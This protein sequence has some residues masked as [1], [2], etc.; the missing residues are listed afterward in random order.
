MLK[1]SGVQNMQKIDVFFLSIII[2]SQ[3]PKH[4]I[5]ISVPDRASQEKVSLFL[6]L[7]KPSSDHY[8]EGMTFQFGWEWTILT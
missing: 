4:P 5:S 8:E 2:I 1:C 7:E 3:E 6:D